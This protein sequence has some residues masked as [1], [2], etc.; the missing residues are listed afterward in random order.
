M[1]ELGTIVNRPQTSWILTATILAS[2][3]VFIDSTAVNVAL[4]ILQKELHATIVDA[5]WFVEAYALFLSALILVGGS[6]GDH[7]GRKRLFLIGV[8]GFALASALCGLARDAQQLIAARA[9]QGMA[10]AVLTPGSLSI[11]GASFDGP[12]RG[13][14]IG[15]WSSFTAITAAAGPVLGGLIVEHAS[16]RWIFFINIPLA[17]VASV[18]TIRCIAESRDHERVHHVDWLGG[19]LATA[20]LGAIVYALIAV[21]GTGWDAVDIWLLVAGVAILCIFVFV[22]ARAPSPM[23]PLQLFANRDFS[24]INVMTLF[25]YA[26]LGGAIFFLPFNLILVQGYSPSASGAAFL[27]FIGL[28]FALSPWAGTLSART[29]PKLPLV[30]GCLISAAGFAGMALPGVGGSYWTTFFPATVVLG[31]GMA[32]VVSPLTTT[33]MGAVDPDHFGVASGINNAVARTAGLL[34]VAVFSL[35]VVAVFN[36]EL[37]ARLA[38]SGAAPQVMRA[39]VAERARLAATQAPRSASPD[40]RRKVQTIVARSYVAGFRVA[41]LMAAALAIASAIC[42]GFF[43]SASPAVSAPVSRSP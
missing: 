17:L 8:I 11:L 15:L 6:L 5:Q 16:W 35:A 10:S 14:A 37:D 18:V 19:A 26:A 34:A 4:P 27:P 29:G 43:L 33:V 3:M 40:V 12:A 25:Q 23:M 41:M 24:A 31:F 28:I 22:E 2:S 13:K 1:S 42:G 32:L 21:S 30:T 39:V 36:R 20:G 7:F 38:S 9:V